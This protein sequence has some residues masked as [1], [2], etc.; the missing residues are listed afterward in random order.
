VD[1]AVEAVLRLMASPGAVGEV[2]HIGNDTDETNI[3]DLAK[4]VLRLTGVQTTVQSM[5]APPG[6]VARRRPDLGKLRGLTGFEPMVGLEEGVRQ[7]VDWYRTRW[8]S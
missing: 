6:S 8:R 7:T 4:L 1:D 3:A 5:P 2:V